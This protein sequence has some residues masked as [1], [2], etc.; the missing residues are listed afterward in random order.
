MLVTDLPQDRNARFVQI[1]RPLVQLT[2]RSRHTPQMRG[3]L[4]SHLEA[5]LVELARQDAV[6]AEADASLTADPVEH[7]VEVDEVPN[8]VHDN[9]SDDPL[10]GL[11]NESEH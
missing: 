8:E 7:K 1:R 4:R 6:D 11:F 9:N 5:I 3:L 10:D 2:N